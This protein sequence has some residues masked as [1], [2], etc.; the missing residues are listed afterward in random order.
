MH[1][2]TCVISNHDETRNESAKLAIAG[3]IAANGLEPLVPTYISWQPK[4]VKLGRFHATQKLMHGLRVQLRHFFRLNPSGMYKRMLGSLLSHLLL[5]VR[6]WF[7]AEEEIRVKLG[8]EIALTDKHIRALISFIDSGA[9]NL[10][11]V[12]DDVFL[13]ESA[14]E[15]THRILDYLETSKK[16]KFTSICEAFSFKELGV[17]KQMV[18][19]G[20]G[21]ASF[22]H[23]FTNTTAAYIVNRVFAEEALEIISSRPAM[24]LLPS[25]WFYNELFNYVNELQ[26]IHANRGILQNG[27]L[28]GK[29]VSRVQI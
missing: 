20:N 24:R 27:S 23:P 3:L 2:M 8:I 19:R 25:D 28:L 16:P 21:N 22:K 26:C 18:I 13:V 17:V 29:V 7:S 9:E 15:N 11:V 10:I 4:N 12:E 6:T 5:L 14:S 1:L